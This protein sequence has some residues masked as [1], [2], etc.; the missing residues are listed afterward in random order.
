MR[1]PTV[2]YQQVIPLCL[3]RPTR[4]TLC[5]IIKEQKLDFGTF[6]P[7]L[8]YLEFFCKTVGES[9]LRRKA[10]IS[11]CFST[12]LDIPRQAPIGLGFHRLSLV[13]A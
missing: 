5:K 1:E 12:S 3:V 8:R 11:E 2:K 4:L 10:H 6:T 9:L 7:F 13:N